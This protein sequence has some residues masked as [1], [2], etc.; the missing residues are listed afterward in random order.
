LEKRAG[1]A[2]RC[3]TTSVNAGDIDILANSL[4]ETLIPTAV[5]PRYFIAVH[6]IADRREER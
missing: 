2:V 4:D 3:R 5:S 1:R 6:W